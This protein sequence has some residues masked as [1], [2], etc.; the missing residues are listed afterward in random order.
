MSGEAVPMFIR[1][2]ERRRTFHT[3][4]VP[5]RTERVK[6]WGMVEVPTWSRS[7]PILNRAYRDMRAFGLTDRQARHIVA[8]LM[9]VP[10]IAS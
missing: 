9:L 4:G 7:R 10:W 3:H 2:G 5:F 1:I 8:D 6:G